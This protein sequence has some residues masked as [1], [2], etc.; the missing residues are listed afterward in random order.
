[1]SFNGQVDERSRRRMVM[2]NGWLI[3]VAASTLV[4]MGQPASAAYSRTVTNSY[5]TSVVGAF[6]GPVESGAWYYD[7]LSGTGCVHVPVHHGETEA[8]I[9]VH[10]R[11]GH[12]VET[13]VFAYMGSE[14]AEFCTTTGEKPIHVGGVGELLIMVINGT[15]KDGTPS[16]VT[17]GTITVTFRK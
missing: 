11:L 5:E 17:S 8:D 1:M 3:A 10:D 2:K 13:K 7:C 15:C 16:V 9:A 6:V 4:L 14:L 12:S